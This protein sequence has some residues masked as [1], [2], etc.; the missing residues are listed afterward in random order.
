MSAWFDAIFNPRVDFYSTSSRIFSSSSYSSRSNYVEFKRPQSC[1]AC[2]DLI[3]HKGSTS[4]LNSKPKRVRLTLTTLQ[5]MSQQE[6][7]YVEN[8]VSQFN[9]SSNKALDILDATYIDTL[10]DHESLWI[11]QEKKYLKSLRL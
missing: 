4:D 2:F 10:Y 3:R 5:K 9:F 8:L 1:E 6:S 11:F 7:Q